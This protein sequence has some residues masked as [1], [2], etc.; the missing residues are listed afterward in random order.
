M[1]KVTLVVV[2]A[3]FLLGSV[4]AF[5][6]EKE[7][8]K[9]FITSRAGDIV[10]VKSMDGNTT[11]VIL[12]D[13]TK[14]IDKKGL[15]GLEKHRLSNTVLIPGLKV[16]VEGTVDEQGRVTAKRIITDGDDLETAE[17]IQ[18]GLHPTADQVATN[19]NNIAANKKQLGAQGQ[20]IQ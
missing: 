14:T 1:R 18:A 15:F 12:T 17:M 2:T 4:L 8:V 20:D 16:S 10:I 13:E 7:K 3:V 5:S 9:G 6:Q 19:V 11:T